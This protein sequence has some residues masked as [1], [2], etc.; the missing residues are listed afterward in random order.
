MLTSWTP[1]SEPKPELGEGM[2]PSDAETAAGE[3][4]G[5]TAAEAE[6]P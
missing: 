6:A 1:A 5:E 3:A 4:S 2:R